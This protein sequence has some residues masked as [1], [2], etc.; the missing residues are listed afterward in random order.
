MINTGR[1]SETTYTKVV[2]FAKAVLWKDRAISLPPFVVSRI[3]GDGISK[4]VF[5]DLKKGE[6]W[7]IATNDFLGSAT[8]KKVGQ[9]A[10]YYC[11]IDLFSKTAITR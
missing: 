8:L 3:K 7:T 2:S 10:Q 11:P 6:R 5:E 4:I 1:F 9:E